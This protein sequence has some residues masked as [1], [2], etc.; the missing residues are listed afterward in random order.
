MAPAGRIYFPRRSYRADFSQADVSTRS[1][2]IHE[3]VHVWQHQ[4]RYRLRWQ[5]LL[6]FLQGGYYRARAYHYDRERVHPF[7]DYNFEQQAQ[8]VAHYYHDLACNGSCAP[9]YTQALVDFLQNPAD[10]DLLPRRA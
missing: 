1:W 4:M 9:F 7:A 6:L 3:M 5:G 8:I 2:F 10:P